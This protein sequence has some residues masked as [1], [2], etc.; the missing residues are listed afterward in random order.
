MWV[1]VLLLFC[2]KKL[3]DF[4]ENQ[5]TKKPVTFLILQEE[6]YKDMYERECRNH[7]DTNKQLTSTNTQLESKIQ[8][9]HN[10]HK[11]HEVSLK[12]MKEKVSN[13]FN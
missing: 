12:E 13:M 11:E 6:Y 1:F 10:L 7:E 2:S 5:K 4:N 9:V 3:T 8:E